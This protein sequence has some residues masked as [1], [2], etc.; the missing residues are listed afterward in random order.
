MLGKGLESLIPNKTESKPAV[1]KEA[2]SIFHIEIDRI[3]SNPHQPRKVFDEA[4]IRELA[5]SIREVGILQPL[6]V[7]KIEK[8]TASGTTVEY[9]LIA[10]ER[11]LL[12]A[13]S[14]GM[15][16]VPAIIKAVSEEKQKLEMALIENVQRT[17]INA[18]EAARAYARLAEEFRMT[19]REIG[20]RIGK[21]RETVSNLIRLLNLPTEFQEAIAQNKL[22]ESQGRLLLAISD[23]VRQQQLFQEIVQN[24][25]SVRELR[26]KVGQFKKPTLKTRLVAEETAVAEIAGQSAEITSLLNQ[27]RQLL[28]ADVFLKKEN[29][30]SKLTIDFKSEEEIKYL[31]D[32]L[33][34]NK[35]GTGDEISAI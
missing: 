5:A 28:G 13:Q 8:E 9:Q 27:L 14:L 6:I 7:S 10:G 1:K 4:Q 25:I 12:A 31:L 30:K 21:S 20:V 35:K 15:R 18:I 32:L 22:S 11:R 19:Q 34:Q 17:D 33:Q 3:Q 29:G 16:T 24:N 23:P 2:D 26:E